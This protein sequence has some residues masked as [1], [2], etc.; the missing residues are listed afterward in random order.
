ML[1]V[2]IKKTPHPPFISAKFKR[3]LIHVV[4]VK[5]LSLSLSLVVW[6]GFT[7]LSDLQGFFPGMYI[8]P[9]VPGAGKQSCFLTLG[10]CFSSFLRKY[11]PCRKPCWKV[12]ACL[13]KWK[14]CSWAGPESLTVST[15]LRKLRGDG[16]P[17]SLWEAVGG[18][19]GGRTPQSHPSGLLWLQ[20]GS[21]QW[22][23]LEISECSLISYYV[24]QQRQFKNR[25]L[26]GSPSFPS[27]EECLSLPVMVTET[28]ALLSRTW[29]EQLFLA[30]FCRYFGGCQWSCC[31]GFVWSIFWN[32]N[33]SLTKGQ[34]E[35]ET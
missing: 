23:Q 28:R 9:A 22:V 24:M 8:A 33:L 17:R 21:N 11:K 35:E 25:F 14:T 15:T 20:L 6:W 19:R 4:H 12:T 13:R 5:N 32:W 10:L 16:A 26:G 2:A 18:C 29:P 3:D 30:S 7:S 27:P 34:R 1:L 31:C